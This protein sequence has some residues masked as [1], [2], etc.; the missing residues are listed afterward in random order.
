MSVYYNKKLISGVRDV[1][2][3][4]L[5]EY[6]ALTNKPKLWL[7]TDAPES[8]RGI[9]A[10]DVEYS[11]GVSVEDM[12]DSEVITV[13]NKSSTISYVNA[14]RIGKLVVVDF[15]CVEITANTVLFT[16]PESVRP[17]ENKSTTQWLP[18]D[19]S[20]YGSKTFS[21]VAS[22]GNVICN[23]GVYRGG[24]KLIYSL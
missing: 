15:F 11:T 22:N 6:N 4:T 14:F 2:Q 18:S 16:L 21:L 8:D 23:Q 24:V 10:S 7:R 9:S 12:L 20:S 1:P 5:A 3:M 17:S 19:A 13:T